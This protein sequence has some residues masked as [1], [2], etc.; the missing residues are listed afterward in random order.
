MSIRTSLVLSYLALVVLLT[1]SMLAGADWV[2]KQ[3]RRTNMAFAEEGVQKISLAALN[4][5][6]Q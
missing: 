6:A 2:G 4:A 5:A 1:L 3:L